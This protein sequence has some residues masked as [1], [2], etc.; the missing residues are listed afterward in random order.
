MDK[1]QTTAGDGARMDAIVR[2]NERLVF[3]L[4]HQYHSAAET[5]K[6]LAQIT[7]HP[8]DPTTIVRLPWQTNYG[9]NTRFGKRCFINV[10]TMFDDLGGITIGDNVL[11][12]PNVQILTVNHPLAAR[13][14][15]DR[16]ILNLKPVTIEDDAW[17]GAGATLTPG[18]TIGRGA[19][20][21]AAAVVTHDVAPFTLVAGVP[22]R[23]LRNL[24]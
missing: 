17:I 15:R 8:I 23:Q 3:Q 7:G 11:I 1:Q 24:N 14:R 2:R 9:H 5:R 16:H 19:V 21:A 20:V 12:A 13:Q 10:N 18:V 4:N 6:L 22:A